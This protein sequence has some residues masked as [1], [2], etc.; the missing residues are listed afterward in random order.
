M[1]EANPLDKETKSNIQSPPVLKEKESSSPEQGE[2]V[3]SEDAKSESK[4]KGRQKMKPTRDRAHSTAQFLPFVAKVGRFGVSKEAIDS[5]AVLWKGKVLHHKKE[6]ELTIAEEYLGWPTGKQIW[7][8][9][10][11]L[12]CD[13]RKG[14]DVFGMADCG[15]SV[16]ER[17]AHF[18][19]CI[20]IKR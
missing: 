14:N 19:H 6:K 10:C 15:G 20:F 8:H 16:Q 17:R 5:S 13:W 12:F 3:L 1:E 11:L 18:C 2:T 7:L 9:F 4:E